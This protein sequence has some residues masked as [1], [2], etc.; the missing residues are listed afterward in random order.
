MYKK[1]YDALIFGGGHH[2]TILA[3]YLAKAGMSV[4]VFER[5][6]R[7]GGGAVTEVGPVPGFKQDFCAHYYPI[8]RASCL[9]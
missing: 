5:T 7:L 4:G 1:S 9:S 3:V 8:L 2:G 6:D